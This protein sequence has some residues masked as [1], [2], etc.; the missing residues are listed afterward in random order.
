MTSVERR[1]IEEGDH[2]LARLHIVR[3]AAPFKS[4]LWVTAHVAVEA[5]ARERVSQVLRIPN[6][7]VP[8]H[9]VTHFYV[10]LGTGAEAERIA[11]H[12]RNSLHSLWDAGLREMLNLGEPYGIR[13]EAELFRR[14]GGLVVPGFPSPT[15]E[16]SPPAG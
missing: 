8:P 7:S 12:M 13:T 6:E 5:V 10:P 16:F 14:A 3:R 2:L 4:T 1:P 11:T 9:N 15:D